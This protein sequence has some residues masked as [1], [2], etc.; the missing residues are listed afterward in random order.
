MIIA[1]PLYDVVFKYLLE[2]VEIAK[3]LLAAILG[4]DIISVELK[5][6]E[7]LAESSRGITVLRFDFNAVIRKKNGELHKVLVEL[8]KA[9]Q[10]MDIMRFR[11]YL[12]ENYRKED[13]VINEDGT[14]E[15]LPLPII[16]IYF[17]GF[18][19][20]NVPSAIVK[21]NR[22]YRDVVTHEVLDIKNEFVELLTHDSY[23]IQVRKLS[24]GP[25]N[26]LERIL[27]VF[28]PDFEVSQD[29]HILDFQGDTDEPLVK[30]IVERLGRAIASE[31]L[32]H[33][34]NLEDELDRI[35]DR[36]THKYILTILEKDEELAQK[37]NELA[38]KES[39]L[40]EKESQ[41]AEKESQLAEKDRLLAAEREQAA[42]RLTE[43]QRE[44][45]EMKKKGL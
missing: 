2:D 42:R 38:E 3:E 19:L 32:R 40:V 26:R 21:I 20:N 43:L 37:D 39:Q 24:D 1:N 34:M 22:V 31:E 13:V 29:K 8:Q 10:P 23:I 36:E 5:P 41:L 11:R 44:I 6:Q 33:N 25:R 35:I 45:E 18:S 28:S 7:T 27:R 12:G 9:K 17:L 4:E 15:S 16:T 14:S 30:K